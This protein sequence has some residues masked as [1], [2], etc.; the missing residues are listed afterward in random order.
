MALLCR[1]RQSRLCEPLLQ[2]VAC[3]IAAGRSVWRRKCGAAPEVEGKYT[4]NWQLSCNSFPLKECEKWY[5]ALR[6]KTEA[7]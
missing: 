1:E 5:Y 4:T 3:S 6:R 7:A 2:G